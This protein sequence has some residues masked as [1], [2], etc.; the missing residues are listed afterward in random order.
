MFS[1]VPELAPADAGL[2]WAY[3]LGV[4]DL[5]PKPLKKLDAY[6]KLDEK[7]TRVFLKNMSKDT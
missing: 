1:L 2:Q 6:I 3:Q 5:D 7:I 4:V